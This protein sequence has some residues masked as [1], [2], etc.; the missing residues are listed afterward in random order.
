MKNL[1][2]LLACII[3]LGCAK[4]QPKE[5]I[6]SDD[7]ACLCPHALIYPFIGICHPDVNKGGYNQMRTEL[8]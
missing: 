7:I 3:C 5:P 1:L 2:V 4:K 6:E 8:K